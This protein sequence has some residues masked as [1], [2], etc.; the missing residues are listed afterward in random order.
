MANTHA[1]FQTNQ[2]YLSQQFGRSL[3]QLWFGFNNDIL[4]AIVGRYSRGKRKNQ[5]RGAIVWTKVIRGGW[6]GGAPGEGGHVMFPGQ[7]FDVA[8][9]DAFTKE[10]IFYKPNPL[11]TVQR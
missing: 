9:V 6:T 2:A 11:D 10:T 5:F 8:I 1:R 7:I 3:A 4:E